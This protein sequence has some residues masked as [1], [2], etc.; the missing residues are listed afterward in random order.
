M[1]E[2]N[3]CRSEPSLTLSTLWLL[4]AKIFGF[5]FNVALPL[6]I[7]RRLSQVEFGH[8]KQIFLAVQS[9]INILPL[10]FGMTAFYFFPREAS[11]RREIMFNIFLVYSGMGILTAI[12]LLLFPASL[13]W[14]FGDTVLNHYAPALAL[15]IPLSIFSSLIEIV[16][17][18]H[19]EFKLATGFI[20]AAQLSRAGLLFVAVLWFGSVQAIVT[21]AIIQ[22][23]IQSIAVFA[24]IQS[25]QPGF[26][27]HFD[28]GLLRR[29]VVYALPLGYA[30][31]LWSFQSD[32]HN[33]FVSHQYG[34]AI[35]AIYSIGCFQLPL[36]NMLNEAASSVMIGRV[37]ELRLNGEIQEIVS[38]S[39]RVARKLAAVAF[40][41][42]AV[43]LVTGREF[44]VFLFT[45]RYAGSW[46]IF[47]VNISIV[48]LIP[49]LLDP[50]IRAYPEYMPFLAKMRTVVFLTM[51]LALW[52]CT[53][54]LGPI[55]A[56][57]IA[58]ASNFIERGT[59]ALYYGR[60]I[61]MR[62]RDLAAYRDTAKIAAATAVG[63]I[64]AAVVRQAILGSKPIVVLLSCGVAF[65][66]SYLVSLV[67][68]RVPNSEEWLLVQ[69]YTA[70]LPF[71]P[72]SP[73]LNP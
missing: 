55:A 70:F 15:L 18:I 39:A 23:A 30:G 1:S 68:L 10:G 57:T 73:K 50:I 58:V 41:F 66:V 27:R 43:L 69:R 65:L 16:A 62:W 56:I 3:P 49:V 32:L 71:V 46:P 25:R 45:S 9:A 54:R 17:I 63:G 35:F 53:G 64:V 26:W 36:M 33:Y 48:L 61:G 12:V 42:Y 5:A 37:S 6:L 21:A 11:Q 47:A 13:G 19:Q 14:L 7:V 38:L 60:A 44:L 29:Q 67:L 51:L 22:A 59:T 2:Q 4:T 40:P 24:Y 20:I 28:F 8:Y 72:S 31:L 52:L 34:P